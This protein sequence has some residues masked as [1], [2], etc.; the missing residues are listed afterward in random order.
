MNQPMRQ[1][2]KPYS[3][4]TQVFGRTASQQNAE[5]LSGGESD[6]PFHDTQSFRPAPVNPNAQPLNLKIK[7]AKVILE[8]MPPQDI[9]PEPV[10]PRRRI[11]RTERNKN[12]YDDNNRDA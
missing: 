5:S 10:V 11:R 9:E 1:E 8:E 4:A 12:L 3:Q 7:T 6:Q 2:T